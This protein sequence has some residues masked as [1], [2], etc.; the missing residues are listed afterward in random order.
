[1]KLIKAA[2]LSFLISCITFFPMEV[3]SADAVPQAVASSSSSNSAG[4]SIGTG[5]FIVYATSSPS[6]PNP[7]GVALTLSKTSYAQYFYVRN[8]GNIDVAR[9]SITI[10]Y[11]AGPGTVTLDRCNVGVSFTALNTCAS[12]N[13]TAM[14]ISNGVL[15]L[16]V[17]SNTWFSFELDPQKTVLPTIN[18]SVSSSQIRSAIVTNS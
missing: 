5:S 8:T 1:M 18:V 7:G 11:D 14:S 12:G 15:T 16:S 6:G 13:K 3:M 4:L 17:P 10:S 9:F 2:L